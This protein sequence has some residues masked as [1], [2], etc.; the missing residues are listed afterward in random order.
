MDRKGSLGILLVLALM[1]APLRAS[2]L[3]VSAGISLGTAQTG[4]AGYFGIGPQLG[5]TIGGPSGPVLVLHDTL[6]LLPVRNALGIDNQIA[7]GGGYSTK[8]VTVMVG[9]LLA[10]YRIPMCGVVLCGAV[11]GFGPG[12]FAQV[13]VFPKPETLLG[14]SARGTLAWYGGES[15]V[16]SDALAWSATAGPVIRWR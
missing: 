10:I 7:I 13:S 4:S 9:G 16:S 8:T 11:M 12:G 3:E 6:L 5:I 1:G 15:L 2:A 14:V